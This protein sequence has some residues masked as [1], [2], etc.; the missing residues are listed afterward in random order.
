MIKNQSQRSPNR[1]RLFPSSSSTTST[2]SH[3]EASRTR[4]GWDGSF[5]TPSSSQI[6]PRR[7]LEVA[8]NE[9][10][11]QVGSCFE[12]GR[13][14]L[15][16]GRKT[17]PKYYNKQKQCEDYER[18]QWE[19]YAETQEGNE[20]LQRVVATLKSTIDDQK[21]D[22]E[23]LEKSK[24]N[25]D[26][27]VVDLTEKLNDLKK[28]N[29]SK[30]KTQELKVERMN[31]LSAK[32]VEE[33][34]SLKKEVERL[35]TNEMDKDKIIKEKNLDIDAKENDLK[36]KIERNQILDEQ[37]KFLEDYIQMKDTEI[38]FLKSKRKDLSA[39]DLIVKVD[40]DVVEP[41]RLPRIWCVDSAELLINRGSN[42]G[43]AG[44]ETEAAGGGVSQEGH[45]VA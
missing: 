6:L 8:E 18:K 7:R 21:H 9:R 24:A 16:Q 1:S 26:K 3:R 45:N 42:I 39:S 27:L 2:S 15:M 25:Q 17:S 28:G 11:Q 40:Q 20:Q 41:L 23:T 38:A 44:V 37:N 34:I 14:E 33:I 31:E 5:K 29:V 19:E 4:D 13:T 32:R 10:K 30:L 35:L 43:Q 36:H 22:I 12:K